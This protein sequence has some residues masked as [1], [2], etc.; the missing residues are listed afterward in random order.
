M[1]MEITNNYNNYAANYTDISKKSESKAT[2]NTSTDSKD[3]VQEY[4]E[5]LCKKFPQI[6][7]NTRIWGD[8][9]IVVENRQK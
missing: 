2:A 1:A 9:P 3:K 7:I 4:Y 5:Q 8:S 6:K